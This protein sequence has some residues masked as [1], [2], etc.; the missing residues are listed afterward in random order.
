MSKWCEALDAATG[1]NLPWRMLREKLAPCDPNKPVAGVEYTKTLH[2]LDT[3][4]FVS[5]F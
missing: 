3:D 4:S 2:L 1:L 5:K